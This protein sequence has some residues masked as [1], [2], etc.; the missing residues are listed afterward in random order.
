VQC[1]RKDEK[2]LRCTICRVVCLPRVLHLSTPA[3]LALLDE[4]DPR[5]LHL[6]ATGTNL[7]LS[8]GRG[9]LREF[10]VVYFTA[11]SFVY[12]L[13]GGN[14]SICGYWWAHDTPDVSWQTYASEYAIC[15]EY[16]TGEYIRQCNVSNRDVLR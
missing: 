12:R 10:S 9:G 3:Y 7:T 13:Y 4:S 16:N 2:A 14:A 6:N 1:T 15:P 8:P 11:S 5:W